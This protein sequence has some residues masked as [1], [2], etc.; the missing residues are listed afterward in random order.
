M[1]D[2]VRCATSYDS[3]LQ[4]TT[5]YDKVRLCITRYDSSL[6]RLILYY[7]CFLDAQSVN[8]EVSGIKVKKTEQPVAARLSQVLWLVEDLEQ[9]FKH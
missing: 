4:G 1:Y 5:M 6:Q 3:V 7:E 8:T 9:E 2:K